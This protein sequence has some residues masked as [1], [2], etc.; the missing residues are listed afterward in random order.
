MRMEGSRAERVRGRPWRGDSFPAEAVFLNGICPYYTMFPL[1]FPLERLRRW[2]ARGWVLDP[3]C[4]RGT[5]L[6]AGRLLGWGVVGVDINPVAEAV[7]AAKLV[8]T[9]PEAVTELA[10]SV[11]RRPSRE[12]EVPEGEFWS[13]A[14]HPDTLR[15]ICV[16]RE[17][18]L[19]SCDRPEE[20]AL[21]ALVLGI[22]HGPLRKGVPTYLS[23]Q[24]PRTYATKPAAA[25]R[26]WRR[27]GLVRPPRVDVVEAVARRAVR[28]FRILPPAVEG[29][30]YRGDARCLDT[31]LP[32]EPRFDLVVTS[33]PYLGMRTYRSDQWLRNWFVGGRPE[34]DYTSETDFPHAPERFVAALAS[35]WRGVA[36]RCRPGAV[37]VVRF[38]C[39][40]GV[41]VGPVDLV[42]RSLAEA[43]AGWRLRRWADAGR[44]DDG[45]R[46]ARQFLAAGRR[47]LREYD[48]EAGLEV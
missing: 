1:E 47:S 22:L 26:Y 31:L 40:P 44:A 7:A 11:L 32:E 9:T 46:Q 16:L 6:F 14:Y 30:V 23:N 17:R 20:I 12:P 37:L 18:L 36:L 5:T 45:R 41:K 48:I 10:R 8:T 34:V 25:V 42:K 28:L 2:G 24:M 33:P 43:N 19:R 13:L 39:L 27:E 15:E 35:V 3:F 38:G 29:W 4:G 21:R